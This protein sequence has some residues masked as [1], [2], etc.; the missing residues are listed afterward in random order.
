[1]PTLD[2]VIKTST[3]IV[4]PGRYA[5]LKLEKPLPLDGYFMVSRD[6]DEITVVTREENL[7]D[8]EYSEAVKWFKLLEIRVS[9]PFLAKGFLA[10]VTK[11]I[12][13]RGLNI[14][15]VSTFSKDYAIVREENLAEAV[16]ALRKRGFSVIL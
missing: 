10:A 7:K 13:D 12:A 1:M 15:I 2:E 9:L 14:L 16:D 11:S 6:E 5:Y 4:R 8:I 3:V